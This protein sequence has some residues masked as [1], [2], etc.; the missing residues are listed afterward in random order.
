[1][2]KIASN[3]DILSEF[4]VGPGGGQCPTYTRILS[5]G[6][7]IGISGN[8]ALAQLV[9]V[10]DLFHDSP[11]GY[12]ISVFNNS[13]WNIT[14]EYYESNGDANSYIIYATDFLEFFDVF[15]DSVD[16][17]STYKIRA[18]ITADTSYSEVGYK[19]HIPFSEVTG[20]SQV[21]IEDGRT[22][23]NIY[24]YPDVN[25][26]I[27]QSNYELDTNLTIHVQY[28]DSYSNLQKTQV[29]IPRGY[30]TGDTSVDSV[31]SITDILSFDPEGT[32]EYK[33]EVNIG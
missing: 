2:T 21:N 26:I 22:V 5:Y 19:I 12:S 1:M 13:P 31:D 20:L 28:E 7:N 8:Y 33:F 10:S 18:D 15:G 17:Y 6:G 3:Q 4:G 27:A 16:F 9:K 32:G 30:T 11:A 23:N 25:L 24:V 29:T 14:M